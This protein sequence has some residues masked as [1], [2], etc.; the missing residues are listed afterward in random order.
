MTNRGGLGHYD[1]VWVQRT[2]PRWRALIHGYFRARVEGLDRLPDGP[3]LGVGNHS[4]ATMMPDTLVWLAEY[5]A[6]DTPTPLLSLAHDAMFSQYP[7]RLSRWMA[8]Y[9]AIRADMDLALRALRAG[10][11]VQVYPGGDHDACRPFAARNRI[12]FAGRTGYVDL[13]RKAG[14]P[15]VPVVSVGAHEALIVLREGRRLA[16]VLGASR[17]MRLQSWP[18]T[19]S[20]PWGLWVGP[21]PGYLPLPTKIAVQV[22]PPIEVKGSTEAVDHTVRQEMQQALDRMSQGRRFLGRVS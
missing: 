20:L 16:R 13:A 1:P 6:A 8:K 4:G 12:V 14:V 17:R 10:F 19:L 18:V 2:A 3:F 9:G 15:I 21:L 7:A 22:L 11:S 5:H